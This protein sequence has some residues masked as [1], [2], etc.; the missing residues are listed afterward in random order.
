MINTGGAASSNLVAVSETLDNLTANNNRDF[1]MAFDKTATYLMRDAKF[2]K[3]PDGGFILHHSSHPP[4]IM[5]AA[6]RGPAQ[7]GVYEVPLYDHQESVAAAGLHSYAKAIQ[8]NFP[9]LQNQVFVI[10]A[11]IRPPTPL[12]QDA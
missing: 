12:A 2:S 11:D 1:V 7:S 8:L 9:F 5:E 4:D 3:H 10:T 6:R